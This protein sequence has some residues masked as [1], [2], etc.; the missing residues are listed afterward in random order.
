VPLAIGLASFVVLLFVEYHETE[1]VSPVKEM[2]HT[3]PL[4]GTWAAMAGGGVLVTFLT[5]LAE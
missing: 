3:F 5:L 2:W 4:I 1:P